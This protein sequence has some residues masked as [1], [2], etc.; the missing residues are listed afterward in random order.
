[1]KLKSIILVMLLAILL[2]LVWPLLSVAAV[3]VQEHFE[4]TEQEILDPEDYIDIQGM[5]NNPRR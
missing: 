5:T 2:T 1:M 3:P 4:A